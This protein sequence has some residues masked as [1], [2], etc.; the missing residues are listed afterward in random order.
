LKSH[1]LSFKPFDII[2]VDS[3]SIENDGDVKV[4]QKYNMDVIHR[5]PDGSGRL[6]AGDAGPTGGHLRPRLAIQPRQMTEC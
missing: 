4:K 2:D 5:H 6:R 1:D 3:I